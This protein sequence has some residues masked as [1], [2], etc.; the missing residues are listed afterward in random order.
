MKFTAIIIIIIVIV[1]TIIWSACGIMFFLRNQ[2][3]RRKP[4]P[5]TPRKIKNHMSVYVC[6]YICVHEHMCM[7]NHMNTKHHEIIFE[8]H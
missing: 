1:R 4:K 8:I 2:S 3:M 6:M 7:F 5:T